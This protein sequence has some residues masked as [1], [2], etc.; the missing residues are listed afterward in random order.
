MVD[1]SGAYL[2]DVAEQNT[3]PSLSYSYDGKNVVIPQEEFAMDASMLETTPGGKLC[4]RASGKIHMSWNE[5]FRRALSNFMEDM[6]GERSRELAL[7]SHDFN[8]VSEMYGKLIISEYFLPD[9]EKT[10]RPLRN[11]GGIAGGAKYLWRCMN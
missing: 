4:R 10:I 11:V 5:R 3:V 2:H 1:D 6:G 8:F 7:V 9:D